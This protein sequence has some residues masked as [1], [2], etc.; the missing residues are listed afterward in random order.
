M[1]LPD[2]LED[3]LWQDIETLE[4]ARNMRYITSVERI[5]LRKGFEKGLEK[6]I[7]QGRSEILLEQLAHRFGPLSDTIVTRVRSG[8][9]TDLDRWARRVLDARTLDEVF[10]EAS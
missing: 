10:S 3:R 2:A 9:A 1:A 5:G 8:S 7:E 4:G 6:G